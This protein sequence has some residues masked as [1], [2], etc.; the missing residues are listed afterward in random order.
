MIRQLTRPYTVKQLQQL[1]S[2]FGTLVE[3]G[4]WIDNIKSTCI[5]KV[6][7]VFEGYIEI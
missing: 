7:K 3:G 4:F 1:L 2:K 6:F 5:A